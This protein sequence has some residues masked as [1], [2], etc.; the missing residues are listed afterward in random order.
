MP[1]PKRCV[2]NKRQAM[3]NVQKCDT[4][5]ILIYLSHKPIEVNY[6]RF[7]VRYEERWKAGCN[8]G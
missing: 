5:V 6:S 4:I 8:Y 2:L 3:D 1:S 7:I